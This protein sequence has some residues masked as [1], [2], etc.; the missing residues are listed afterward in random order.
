MLI[1]PP[2]PV[3][4]M[5]RT[6]RQVRWW[7]LR[8]ADY[9]VTGRLVRLVSASIPLKRFLYTGGK[10]PP[11]MRQMT[12]SLEDVLLNSIAYILAFHSSQ[13]V[14]SFLGMSL[15]KEVSVM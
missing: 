11:D 14:P 3:C 2:T 15:E 12:E 1:V 9:D 4:G 13:L 7:E 6:G 10:Q 5:T 8:I